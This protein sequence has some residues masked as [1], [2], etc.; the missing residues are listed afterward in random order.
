MHTLY[1]SHLEIPFF[2]SPVVV[3]VAIHSNA[4]SKTIKLLNPFISCYFINLS[5]WRTFSCILH[6]TAVSFNLLCIIFIFYFVRESLL[7]F[8]FFV[9]SRPEAM[10]LSASLVVHS[11]IPSSRQYDDERHRSFLL[12]I[13][14]W[15]ISSDKLLHLMPIIFP[16]RL[17]DLEDDKK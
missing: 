1:S 5:V 15:L 10:Q 11:L 9:F 6:F 2:A 4:P 17:D 7:Q 3:A 8:L 13:F 14:M 12:F 16:L